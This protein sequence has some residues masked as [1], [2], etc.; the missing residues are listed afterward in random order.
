VLDVAPA[1][2]PDERSIL[3]LIAGLFAVTMDT[4]RR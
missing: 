1:A 4:S 3:R 2:T